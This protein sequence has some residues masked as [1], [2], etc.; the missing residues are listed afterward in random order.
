MS[1]DYNVAKLD[2]TNA[3]NRLR[4]DT[5]SN[6]V[7]EKIPELNKFRYLLY[8]FPSILFSGLRQIFSNK[9]HKKDVLLAIYS[10]IVLFSHCYPRFRHFFL[11]AI[12][13]ILLSVALKT[14]WSR[15]IE[16]SLVLMNAMVSISIRRNLNLIVQVTQNPRGLTSTIIFAHILP[17]NAT[18]LGTV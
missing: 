9:V 10:S 5:V 12:L 6:E 2:F 11:P 1:A 3:F 18:L 8:G 17:Q 15:T 13:M 4:M 7:C 16:K 14:L